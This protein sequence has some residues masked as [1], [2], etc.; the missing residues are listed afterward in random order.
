MSL[1][2]EIV[3]EIGP[4]LGLLYTGDD[5]LGSGWISECQLA[6]S[7]CGYAAVAR[8]SEV[9]SMRLQHPDCDQ[10][11]NEASVLG[12]DSAFLIA[13]A[14]ETTE[15]LVTAI[16]WLDIELVD[17]DVEGEYQMIVSFQ[18]MKWNFV[19]SPHSSPSRSVCLSE[20]PLETF[21]SSR[22]TERSSFR[23]QATNAAP[24]VAS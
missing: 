16:Q 7:W 3:G 9:S 21:G 22:R 18:Q 14:C 17:V 24:Y 11:R 8:G 2:K 20:Q 5:M 13:N 23:R 19:S 6:I 12:A 4:L 10:G 1:E 15:D